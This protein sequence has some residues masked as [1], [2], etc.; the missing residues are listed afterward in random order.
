MLKSDASSK[1][2]SD[3]TFL[4]SWVQSPRLDLVSRFV[5]KQLILVLIGF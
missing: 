2:S 4:V 3:R 5:E 1:G